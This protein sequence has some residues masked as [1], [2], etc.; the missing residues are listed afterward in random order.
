[1]KYSLTTSR[2]VLMQSSVLSECNIHFVHVLT[3]L[4]SNGIEAVSESKV[5][6]WCR[7][8]YIALDLSSCSRVRFCFPTNFLTISATIY[9]S[10][11][12]TPASHIQYNRIDNTFLKRNSSSFT[13]K[14][15]LK[16]CFSFLLQ[17][18]VGSW[19]ENVRLRDV[20]PS[21]KSV[22]GN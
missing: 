16:S 19:I 3:A 1:V 8:A 22:L 2:S 5:I 20:I 6:V 4:R 12:G 15:V 18:W 9:V 7:L 13:F 10:Y 21:H 14:T 11:H 17:S